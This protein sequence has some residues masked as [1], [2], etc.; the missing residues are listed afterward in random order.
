MGYSYKGADVQDGLASEEVVLL[1]FD[2][3]RRGVFLGIQTKLILSEELGPNV[4]M[5][6]ASEPSLVNEVDAFS[7]L[8]I[9]VLGVKM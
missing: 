9:E 6:G 2:Y 5:E 1:G 3:N 8:K 7:L 4:R